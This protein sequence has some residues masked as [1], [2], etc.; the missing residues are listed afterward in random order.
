MLAPADAG[1]DVPSEAGSP[2]PIPAFMPTATVFV[3]GHQYD[4]VYLDCR[5]G[6][7]R[8][9]ENTDM[10]VWNGATWLVHRSAVSQQLGPNSAL[11]V[12]KSTDRGQT[13]AQTAFID[14]PT[15]RDIRDP[16][17]FVVGK[18][19]RTGGASGA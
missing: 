2:V 6:Y 5:T 9:N 12:Y 4:D 18:Q 17:F 1:S 14:A 7:C 16:S 8:H 13:F 3:D 15:T 10:I 11:H 19:L